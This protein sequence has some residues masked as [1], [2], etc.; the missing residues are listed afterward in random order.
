ML[1]GDLITKKYL[2]P[3]KPTFWLWDDEAEAVTHADGG[4]IAFRVELAD[5]LERIGDDGLPPLGALLMAM[6]AARKSSE[7]HGLTTNTY[8]EAISKHEQYGQY[9]PGGLLASVEKKLAEFHRVTVAL[10]DRK[11][12]STA[13]EIVFEGCVTEVPADAAG[14]VIETLRA[15]P[16]PD[17]LKGDRSRDAFDRTLLDL[18]TLDTG[19]GRATED[20]IRRRHQT[21]VDEGLAPL[22]APEFPPP[23]HESALAVI[24]ELERHDQDAP[25]GKLARQLLA[26]IRLPRGLGLPHDLPLGGLNDITSRGRLDRLLISELA[27]D[28]L[29]LAARVANNEAL[30]LRREES[31]V[32]TP[33][34]RHVLVDVGLNQWGVP[35]L[36]SAATALALSADGDNGVDLRCWCATHD[37]VEPAS[38]ATPQ[39][40]EDLLSRLEVN[41]TPTVAADRLADDV[42]N[43]EGLELVVVLSQSV[44]SDA[45][46]QQALRRFTP[47]PIY[48]VGIDRSGRVEVAVC[49]D[50]GLCP[51]THTQVDVEELLAYRSPTSAPLRNL[52]RSPDLPAAIRMNRLPLRVP[53]QFHS[54]SAW[55]SGVN[56]GC[57]YAVTKDHRMTLWDSRKHGPIQLCDD[58]P[59][60]TVLW[61]SVPSSDDPIDA[62]IGRVGKSAE[63]YTLSVNHDENTVRCSPVEL[64][65]DEQIVGVTYHRGVVMASSRDTAYAIE[66]G[67]GRVLAERVVREDRNVKEMR[68]R[69]VRLSDR[70]WL[71]LAFKGTSIVTVPIDPPRELAVSPKIVSVFE[72]QGIEGYVAVTEEG[73]VLTAY[74]LKQ[75][76]RWLAKKGRRVIRT[77]WSGDG[78]RLI[79]QFRERVGNT[80]VYVMI[81][82]EPD[83][84]R[85]VHESRMFPGN[86]WLR[87]EVEKLCR[88]RS[89]RV[90][91]R[92]VSLV[93]D[94]H[95]KPNIRLTTSSDRTLRMRSQNQSLILIEGGSPSAR[96]EIKTFKPMSSPS[97]THYKLMAAD[98]GDGGRIVLDSRGMLHLQTRDKNL[99]EVTLVIENEC[100]SGWCS[101]GRVF[102]SEYYF[103]NPV[104]A[105]DAKQIT[106]DFAYRSAILPIL[107]R[108][109]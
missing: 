22:E 94:D 70:H 41:L 108:M 1:T 90:K 46:L 74:G 16:P 78:R 87:P 51:H 67:T 96:S 57:V 86:A 7:Q 84:V 107:E 80:S 20:T 88:H 23:I 21:G 44:V 49:T 10:E 105:T 13:L 104:R 18:R 72:A 15:G 40:F 32:R 12:V 76:T 58:L 9:L 92:G 109:G 64:P 71:A 34:R 50:K 60:A 89:P 63:V 97:G 82:I 100:V 98:F 102:G 75:Q 11:L 101:D 93:R 26:T 69:F 66:P 19:L 6:H 52:S 24:G 4:V 65:G 56:G 29:T 91:Y 33:V 28:D 14:V 53:H 79:I 99:A 36:I 35:R 73:H 38:A 45:A 31:H 95:G 48:L 62:L 25:L 8:S 83:A 85:S 106:G 37:G 2:S 3:S 61:H 55:I 68:G 39:K 17:M 77:L 42:A 27:Q 5:T 103:A 81:E 47:N 59:A 54:G 30:Y 43:D